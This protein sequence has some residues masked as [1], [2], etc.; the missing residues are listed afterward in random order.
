ML[1]LLQMLA[2]AFNYNEYLKACLKYSEHET[3]NF[4]LATTLIRITSFVIGW[5]KSGK[6]NEMINAE[7][8]AINIANKIYFATFL[9]FY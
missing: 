5:L 1:A 2:F 6:L 3:Y 8:S 7:K 9:L 4:L